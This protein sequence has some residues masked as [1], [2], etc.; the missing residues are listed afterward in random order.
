MGRSGSEAGTIQNDA[1]L[2]NAATRHLGGCRSS[3]VRESAFSRAA[4]QEFVGQWN[5]RSNRDW[6]SDEFH[7]LMRV[8][9]AS[10]FETF[11]DLSFHKSIRIN[12]TVSTECAPICS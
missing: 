6:L 10:A 9:S 8:R 7:G 12:R 11:R 3:Q 5:T 4:K 2:Q 1:D